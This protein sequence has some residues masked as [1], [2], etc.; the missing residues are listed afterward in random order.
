MVAFHVSKEIVVNSHKGEYTTSF[1]YGAIDKLNDNPIKNSI[2]LIDRKICNL[3]GDR[4]N[5]ILSS[6]RI[7]KIDANEENKSLDRMPGYVHELVSLKIKRGEKLIA[8]GGGIIQDITCFLSSTIMRGLEWI[9]YP[10][11]LLSVV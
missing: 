5:N 2:Y 8:I 1:I 4:I 7:I 10:T 6:Q 3:Y 11:T 9:F